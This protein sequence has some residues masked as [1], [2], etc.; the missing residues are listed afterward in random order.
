MSSKVQAIIL[1][2]GQ[3][4][5]LRPYTAV[6]PKPLMPVGEHPI[7][8]IIIRQLKDAE[9]TNIV[10]STGHLAGLIEAYFGN[11]RKW[12]VN[13]TYVTEDKPLGTAGALK[14]VRNMDEDCLIINGDVLTDLDFKAALTY[15]RRRKALA[16]ITVKE[17]IVKTDFGVIAMNADGELVDYIEKPEHKSFVSIGVYLLS[18][19]CRSYIETDENIG[20]PEL[21]LRLKDKGKKVCC[22]PTKALW[23]DLGRIDDFMA[24]QDFFEK[25]KNKFLKIPKRS[26][27]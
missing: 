12:G 13:I 2:G 14:L 16:T 7:C 26:R 25:H 22:F 11:G 24:S 9:L 19:Q 17:R 6:I 21:V 5:R 23:L 27:S 4:T 10:I 1:A 20:M 3:G 15:H 18:R 8:E